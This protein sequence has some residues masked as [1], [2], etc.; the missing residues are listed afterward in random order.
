MTDG[1]TNSNGNATAVDGNVRSSDPAAPMRAMRLTLK[2]GADD[3][4][5]M[6]VAL[7][8]LATQIERGELT[9]GVSGGPCSGAIY[10]L[11]TDP[12]QTHENYFR[13][14]HEYLHSKRG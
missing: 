1:N 14:L 6:A 13:Q 3:A 2:L 7:R 10:E 5:E 9:V 11:L 12:T 4:D 8:N